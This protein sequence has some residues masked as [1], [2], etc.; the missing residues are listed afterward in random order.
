MVK[1][2]NSDGSYMAY[3]TDGKELFSKSGEQIGY[4]LNGFLYDRT[5]KAIG[6]VKGS[7]VLDKSGQTLY[8][9]A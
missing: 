6:H 3:C 5:G 7:V 1:Y 4:F 2:Y 8:Y 9:T